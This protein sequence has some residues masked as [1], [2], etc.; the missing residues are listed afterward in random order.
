MFDWHANSAREHIKGTER[1][2]EMHQRAIKI[3][4]DYEFKADQPQRV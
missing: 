3:L 2:I 4:K 1:A